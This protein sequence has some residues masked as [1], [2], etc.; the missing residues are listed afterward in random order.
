MRS[1]AVRVLAMLGFVLLFAFAGPSGAMAGVPEELKNLPTLDTLQREENPLNKGGAWGALP[2]TIGKG[3]VSNNGWFSTFGQPTAPSGASWT[4]TKYTDKTGGAA[5]ELTIGVAPSGAGSYGGLW[6]DSQPATGTRTGYNLKWAIVSGSTYTV[7]ILRW[8]AN[9]QTTIA[10]QTGVTIPVGSTL[11]LT[12][13][14]G[15]VTAWLGQSGVFTP[16]VTAADSTFSEGYAGIEAGGIGYYRAFKAGQLA[17]GPVDTYIAA[18]SAE[19]ET[20]TTVSFNFAASGETSGL[21]ECSLDGKAY[22]SCVTPKKYEGLA[23]G[24][25]TFRVRAL[26]KM[27]VPDATPA[28]RKFEVVIP[29]E[30][31]ITSPKHAYT[32]GEINEISFTSDTPG[33]TFKCAMGFVESTPTPTEPCTS[34]TK[35]EIYGTGWRTFTVAATDPSGHTDPT[36][37][38]YKFTQA[39]YPETKNA[40]NKIIS[41]GDNSRSSSYY[42][43]QAEW[44]GSQNVDGLHGVSFQMKVE[45]QQQFQWVPEQYVTDASGDPVKWPLPISGQQGKTPPVHF[46]AK[47]YPGI[48]EE[49]T[50]QDVEFRAVFDGGPETGTGVSKPVFTEFSVRWSG[51]KDANETVGPVS[52]N[53]STGGYTLNATDVSIA[54]PGS[55]AA[56]NFSRVYESSFNNQQ[57]TRVLDG[58]WTPSVPVEQESEATTWVGLRERHDAGEPAV[59]EEGEVVEPAIPASDWVEVLDNEGYGINFDVVN[60]TYVA[61]EYAKEWVLSKSGNLF[62]LADT[63]GT[64]TTFELNSE[65]NVGEYHPIAVSWQG[66]PKSARLVYEL[67]GSFPRL[68][69]MIAP[70]A[71]GVTCGDWTSINEVG[72]RTLE[73]KY[74]AATKWNASCYGSRLTSITYHPA[75]GTG[76]Q[77]V[78]KY[79]YYETAPYCKLKAQ[80]DPRLSIPKEVYTYNNQ[81]LLKTVTPPGE[82]PWTFNYYGEGP[83][84]PE[85]DRLKSVTRPSLISA[86]PTAQ[87]TIVYDVPVSGSGAPYPMS[88]DDVAKWDQKGYPVDATAIFPPTQI[89][90]E[91]TTDYSQASVY[92]LGPSGQVVNT[93]AP[94]PPGAAG[95]SIETTEYDFYGNVVRTLGA[96]NRL[97][98]L[99]AANPLARSQE[100]DTDSVY[101][102]DGTKLNEEWG[103]LHKVKLASGSTVE[104]R[105]HNTISYDEGAPTPPAGTPWPLMPT[106]EVSGARIPGQTSDVDA[107]TT[108][109]FYNWNLRKPSEVVED[110]G[111]LSRRSIVV[112]DE[113]TG[114]PVEKRMPGNTAGGGAGTTK[115]LYYTAGA[116]PTEAVCGNKPAWANLPCRTML[117]SQPTPAE[118]NPTI[119][120]TRYMAYNNLD[121]PLEITEVGEA[122]VRRTTL[123]TYDAAGRQLTKKQTAG[124]GTYA[125]KTENLYS[126]TTGAPV[127]QQLVCEV[128]GCDTQ[129]SLTTLDKL[130]RPIKYQDADGNVA[131]TAYNLTGFPAITSDGKGTQTMAYDS[132]TGVLNSVTDSNAGT[133]TAKYDADGNLVEQGLP[134]GLVARTS[135]DEIGEPVHL[136][137]VKATGCS[138]NC[139]WFQTDVISSIRGQLREEASSLA[140]HQ[141]SYD[142]LGR[143]VLATDQPKASGCTTRAY[144][145]DA[146]SNRTKLTTRAPGTGG[147]C[148]T[149]SAGTVQTYGYDTADRLLGEGVVYDNLGRITQLPA[150]F[151]GGGTLTTTYWTNDLIK[152]QTQDGITNTYELDGAM[153]QRRLVTTGG[154]GAGSEIY[155]YESPSDAPAWID[156]GASWTRNI[157]GIGGELAAIYSSSNG[158]TLQLTDLHGDV[159]ATASAEPGATAVL[160]TNEFDEFG[161]PKVK[162]LLTFGWLGGQQRRSDL[163]SGVVQMGVRA[164]IPAIGRFL[165]PDPIE[166]GSANAYDYAM[167]DPINGFDLTGT[168]SKFRL[169][170][171]I[172]R[173]R[174]NYKSIRG[175][176]RIAREMLDRNKTRRLA[177]PEEN[178]RRAEMAERFAMNIMKT[179]ARPFH[180]WNRTCRSSYR[181]QTNIID[182]SG[183][184][185]NGF[186]ACEESLK[187]LGIRQSANEARVWCN[188]RGQSDPQCKKARRAAKENNLI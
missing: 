140:T 77:E 8:N 103:P 79:E 113:S 52:L 186:T 141:Y 83:L 112:Y 168:Q 95:P 89:P 180:N 57:V 68:A 37:A 175:A 109:T 50:E 4:P 90:G 30:T 26:S 170:Y 119:P 27:G 84:G 12:D 166:G 80:W 3:A 114:L 139:V 11:A 178:K 134:G 92:Y 10:S 173:R 98:A 15:G 151:A 75:S 82:E 22:A 43:L 125:G 5:A 120:T 102:K 107:T 40:N 110:Y 64:K 150:K 108:R 86:T 188:H 101:S 6:L 21:F 47:A 181:S 35:R 130:G 167:Q 154:S 155:H 156:A 70:S 159:V 124:A 133:F 73:F 116:H 118:A 9:S 56:L 157:T 29:P 55:D 145:Y 163:P 63:N 33:S 142:A 66:N 115:L 123:L 88:P 2:A 111:G 93:A 46:D 7:S 99:Q 23:E 137:Y 105:S 67:T 96:G 94:A 81:N 152:S 42:T 146:D 117:A 182:P 136:E 85:M 18:G 149:T 177:D 53:L 126:P 147:V 58:S 162:D 160:D 1:S 121:Q 17:A 39:Y 19:G 25:H 69:R 91:P 44:A 60:G 87:T 24:F 122:A 13:T 61:P 48:T 16:I 78:S 138:A 71:P 174:Q 153:R 158:T 97:R 104:A 36:P 14:G 129:A 164:Y 161:I 28:E 184:V 45:G 176:F 169:G 128:V 183:G 148:D 41:P 165:S 72:C 187:I 143:L 106:T 76:D 132:V 185:E 32:N 179:Y 51:D 65:G 172:E 54:V 34:P 31:T 135:Y 49:Q 100:L 20:S 171:R 127:G 62:T 59:E 74:E 131:E 38:V 144:G